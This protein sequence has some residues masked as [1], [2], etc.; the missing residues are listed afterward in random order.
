MSLC[1]DHEDQK[2][3]GKLIKGKKLQ[4]KTKKQNGESGCSLPLTVQATAVEA[5]IL[6]SLFFFN[7]F[8]GGGMCQG[9]V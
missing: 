7:L 3:I 9:L 5:Q 4:E 8:S 2:K 1:K 6:E